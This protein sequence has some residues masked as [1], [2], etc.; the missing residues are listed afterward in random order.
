MV[1]TNNMHVNI[2][3]LSFIFYVYSYRQKEKMRQQAF[4]DRLKLLAEAGD[5]EAIDKKELLRRKS[6]ERFIIL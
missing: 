5:T 6:R 4:R 3:K 1:T 2:P